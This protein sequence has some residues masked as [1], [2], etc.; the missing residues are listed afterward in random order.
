PLFPARRSSDLATPVSPK[1]HPTWQSPLL[2][3]G[4]PS[5]WRALPP[6]PLAARRAFANVECTPANQPSRCARLARFHERAS[7]Q[8]PT[9]AR[10]G[11]ETAPRQP[12][13]LIPP[14]LLQLLPL[15]RRAGPR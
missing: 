13:P 15:L 3:P 7:D 6:R 11:G 10:F 9:R 14:G 4:Q 1:S 12:P 2:P 8:F 5:P